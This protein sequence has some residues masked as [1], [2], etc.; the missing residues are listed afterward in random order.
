MGTRV[1]HRSGTTSW[2]CCSIRLEAGRST[3]IHSFSKTP[4]PVQKKPRPSPKLAPGEE[5]TSSVICWQVMH[6]RSA[7]S[8]ANK[9]IFPSKFFFLFLPDSLGV[10]SHIC[11]P[12]NPVTSALLQHPLTHTRHA[13]SGFF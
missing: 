6:R 2:S 12:I 1:T 4:F 7:V 13:K 10:S 3:E 8:Q 9:S 11:I 5:N